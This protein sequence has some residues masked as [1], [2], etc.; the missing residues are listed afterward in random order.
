MPTG[1]LPM[2][3]DVLHVPSYRRLL[4]PR[5]CAVVATIHDL[6]PFRLPGKY[7]LLRMFYGRTVA[8]FTA[9]KKRL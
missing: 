6:A 4:W 2:Q 8:P 7:D 9:E 1:L 3:L 5:P